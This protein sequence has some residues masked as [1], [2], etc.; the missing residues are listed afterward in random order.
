[1]DSQKRATLH[2]GIYKAVYAKAVDMSIA[3]AGAAALGANN[4]EKESRF[5]E[6]TSICLMEIEA[7][8]HAYQRV[9]GNEPPPIGSPLRDG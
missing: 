8:R 6:V 5:R 2:Q 4:S 1:V 3:R 7:L 9:T